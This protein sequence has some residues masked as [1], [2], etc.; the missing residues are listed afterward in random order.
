MYPKEPAQTHASFSDKEFFSSLNFVHNLVKTYQE[1]LVSSLNEAKNSEAAKNL[2]DL[3]A[4]LP[5]PLITDMPVARPTSNLLRDNRGNA[6]K[7]TTLI[8][9]PTV[10]RQFAFK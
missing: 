4:K 8:D 3:L 7:A 1:H 6:R 5:T 10:I 2:V 9:K